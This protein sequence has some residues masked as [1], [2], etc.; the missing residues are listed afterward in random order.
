[1]YSNI[2]YVIWQVWFGVEMLWAAARA[3]Y[4]YCRLYSPSPVLTLSTPC[5]A[6]RNVTQSPLLLRYWLWSY[7]GCIKRRVCNKSKWRRYSFH[8]PRSVTLDRIVANLSHLY[9]HS[10]WMRAVENLKWYL[11]WSYH[12]HSK[13]RVCDKSKWQ[14]YRIAPF[15]RSPSLTIWPFSGILVTS[16]SSQCVHARSRK[17]EVVFAVV[18]SWS[19]Q[20]ESLQQVEMATI[21][22]FPLQQVSQ[23]NDVIDIVADLSHLYL[24]S[25]CMHAVENLKRYWLWSY[26]G[27]IKRKVCN[28]LKWQRYR[29]APFHRTSWKNLNGA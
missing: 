14:R 8:R 4:V 13:R 21:K 27:Q 28:K 20:R 3:R 15:N 18:I 16:I 22:N 29:I 26:H 11:L 9:L 10:A 7:R 25:A 19:F 23:S 6:V 2:N 5:T 17:L 1:M 24:R 12:G